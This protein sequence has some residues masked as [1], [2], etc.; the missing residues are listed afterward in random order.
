MKET[1]KSCGLTENQ[2]DIYIALLKEGETSASKLA[3]LIKINRSTIYQE[4]NE[5]VKQGLASYVI[6]DFKR[7]YKASPPEQILTQLEDKKQEIK[8]ILPQLKNLQDT[9]IKPLID[10]KVYEGKEGIKSFYQQILNEKPKEVLALGVTGI[11]WEILQ[12]TFPHFVKE[13]Q[14]A[15]IKSRY[16][17]NNDSKQRLKQH[18]KK[19]LL[20]KY[21]PKETYSDVTTIIFNDN[22][23]IQSLQKEQIYVVIIRDKK[24][25][26]GYKNY[27]KFIWK[28]TIS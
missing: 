26:Q 8:S 7:Y 1:L 21:L 28:S 9:S 6:K 19:N 16:L 5:L 10:I 4:L 27:F 17:A 13:Y 23:A 12:F 22:I 25:A 11:A 2:A 14:K 3:K 15:G 18:P 20:I 24:L